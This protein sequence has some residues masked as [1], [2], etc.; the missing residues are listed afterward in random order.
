MGPS[1]ERVGR[2]NRPSGWGGGGG[3]FAAAQGAERKAP[4]KI[5]AVEH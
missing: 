1:A 3:G 5:R 4:T 2:P